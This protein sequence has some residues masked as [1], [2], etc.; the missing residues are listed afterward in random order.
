VKNSDAERAIRCA[1]CGGSRLIPLTVHYQRAEHL[2]SLQLSRPVR[3]QLKCIACG[4]RHYARPAA[5]LAI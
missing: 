5:L 2:Q 1:S 3:A 4:H